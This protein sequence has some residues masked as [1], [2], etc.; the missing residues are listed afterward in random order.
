[1]KTSIGVDIHAAFYQICLID[2]EGAV[3]EARFDNNPDGHDGLVKFVT[4]RSG[5]ACIVMEACTGAYH[6][7][8]I[9]SERTCAEV[10]IVDPRKM[11]ER[12]PKKG[13]KTDRVDAMNLAKMASFGDVDGIY[14]PTEETRRLRELTSERCRITEQSTME[15][16]RIHAKL[17]EQ[18]LRYRG[19]SKALWTKEGLKWLAAQTAK[20]PVCLQLTMTST[21]E[22]LELLQEQKLKLESFICRLAQGSPHTQ[23][24]MTLP[25]V[26]AVGATTLLAEI[27][28]WKRFK[29]AKQLVSF[30][31]LNPRVSQ[32]AARCHHGSISKMGRSRLR[33]ICVEMALT[34]TQNCQSLRSFYQRIL[35][36]TR[37]AGKAKVATARKLLTLCWHVLSSNRAYEQERE[38]LNQ[39]KQART[40]KRARRAEKPSSEPKPSRF[41][42]IIAS[43]CSPGGEHEARSQIELAPL[44]L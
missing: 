42:A 3:N 18:G 34:A 4:S 1:M 38:D 21:L 24:L 12:F 14:V 15:M 22:R 31:G 27:G 44:L 9:L 17:K 33:W 6:L 40:A 13:K 19:R 11:R 32:S 35:K 23:L 16:N 41:S 39:R 28:E 36:R 7:H 8:G 43:V 2:Q 29:S 10:L 30:G 25:G 37:C 5:P 26:G 20:L